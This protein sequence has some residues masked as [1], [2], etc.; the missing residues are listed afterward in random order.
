MTRH[1]VTITSSWLTEHVR[2]HGGRLWVV[3]GISVVG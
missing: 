2:S 1:R 3:E